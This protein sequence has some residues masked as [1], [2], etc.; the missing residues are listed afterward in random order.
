MPLDRVHEFLVLRQTLG[1]VQQMLVAP[2]TWDAHAVILPRPLLD[3]ADIAVAPSIVTHIV[4]LQFVKTQEKAFYREN[5]T[6]KI[7]PHNFII[8][9]PLL[10]PDP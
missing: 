5:R 8:Q 1:I 6:P 3:R 4:H 2:V 7:L 10:T 9:R